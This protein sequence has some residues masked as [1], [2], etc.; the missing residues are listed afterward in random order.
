V[1]ERGFAQGGSAGRGWRAACLSWGLCTGLKDRDRSLLGLTGAIL[2]R[3]RRMLRLGQK[4]CEWS[5]GG[6][7]VFR[8]GVKLVLCLPNLAHEEFDGSHLIHT[9]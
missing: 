5:V 1:A 3:Q 4:S 8:H 6:T 9:T 7:L 2:S